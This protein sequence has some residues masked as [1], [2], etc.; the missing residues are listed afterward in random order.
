MN[1]AKIRA[2]IQ[3]VLDRIED[4]MESAIQELATAI[5]LVRKWKEMDCLRGPVE[6]P[7]PQDK[8]GK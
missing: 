6:V 8:E 3:E 2:E 5:L 4:H 1:D 7:S